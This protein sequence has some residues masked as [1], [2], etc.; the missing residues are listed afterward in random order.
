MEMDKEQFL[1]EF[2][3]DYGYPD[4]PKSIDEIRATGFK[5]LGN[6]F[7]TKIFQSKNNFLR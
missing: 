5:R 4:G 2:G 3:K 7:T 6:G 1:E